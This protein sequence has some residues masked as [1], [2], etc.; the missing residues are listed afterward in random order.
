[1]VEQLDAGA[2][3]RGDAIE[4]GGEALGEPSGGPIR[5]RWPR[6]RPRLGWEDLSD[7]KVERSRLPAR[8]VGQVERSRPL[9]F[10]Q[11]RQPGALVLDAGDRV[12]P[13]VLPIAE[14]PRCPDAVV[15]ANLVHVLASVLE[16]DA[17]GGSV[18]VGYVRRGGGDLGAFEA[19]WS[20]A[21]HLSA[22]QE[23]VRIRAEVAIG[24]DRA[25]IL[26]TCW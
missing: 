13:L 17:P 4:D 9:Q 16:H 23:V 3:G 1:M 5:C 24:L 25:R 11:S 14:V 15:A 12:L 22:H 21:L 2:G 19:G 20:A 10:D 6:R 8:R 18:V 7:T 26:S